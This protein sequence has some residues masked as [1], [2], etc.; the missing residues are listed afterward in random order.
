MSAMPGTD[1]VVAFHMAA[2]EIAAVVRAQ[3][4]ERVELATQIENDDWRTV[5]VNDAPLSRR[6]LS[7]RRNGDP[8]A[9]TATT[10]MSGSNCRTRPSMPARVPDNELGQLPQAP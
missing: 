5:R 3:V 7:D 8:V 9:Q 1:D 2:G 10:S 4:F 6:E